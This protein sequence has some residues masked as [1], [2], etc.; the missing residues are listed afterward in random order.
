[1]GLA[2][3]ILGISCFIRYNKKNNQTILQRITL[4]PFFVFVDPR[5]LPS[6]EMITGA[7]PIAGEIIGQI[8]VRGM[9][10][11]GVRNITVVGNTEGTFTVAK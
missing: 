1:M 8:G 5:L 3:R 6:V 4:P 10:G 2:L 11:L 7:G 9:H